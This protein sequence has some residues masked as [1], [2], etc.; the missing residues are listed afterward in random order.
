M[1]NKNKESSESN[2]ARQRYAELSKQYEQKVAD[3]QK[4]VNENTGLQGYQTS[5]DAAAQNAGKM[6]VSQAQ[7]AANQAIQAG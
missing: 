5:L 4:L 6:S 2:A 3:Y 7:G 1:G